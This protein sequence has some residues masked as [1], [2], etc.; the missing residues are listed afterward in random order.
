MSKQGKYQ[1]FN[2]E[3]E[4]KKHDHGEEGKMVDDDAIPPIFELCEKHLSANLV[5]LDDPNSEEICP[6]CTNKTKKRQIGL[7]ESNERLAYLGPGFP[8]FFLFMKYTIVM[9][10]AFLVIIGIYGMYSNMNGS[11]CS[12]DDENY[13]ADDAVCYDYFYLYLSL[14]NKK[15]DSDAMDIQLWLNF[16]LVLVMIV[17]IQ[18][19][20]RHVRITSSRCDERDISAADYSIMVEH[21]PKVDGVDYKKELKE[22]IENEAPF[23]EKGKQVKFEVCKINLTYNLEEL[24]RLKEIEKAAVKKKT[25][26]YVYK[27]KNNSYP[28]G[29][30]DQQLEAEINQK[31]KDISDYQKLL[32]EGKKGDFTGVAFVSLKTEQMKNE[33]I[34]RHKIRGFARFRLAFFGGPATGLKMRGQRLYVSQAAEPGDVYWENLHYTDKQ[35]YTR[36]F[37]GVLLTFILLIICGGLIFYLTYAESEIKD[38]SSTTTTTTTTATSTTNTTS[39]TTDNTTNDTTARLLSLYS[40]KNSVKHYAD[41]TDDTTTTTTTTTDD[42]TTDTTTT[43]SNDTTSNT[44]TDSSNTTEASTDTTSTDSDSSSSSTSTMATYIAYAL[45]MVIVIINKGLCFA[46]PYVAAFEKNKTLTDVYSSVATKLSLALFINSALVSYL[47][48]STYL[49]NYSGSSGLIYNETNVFV[50]NAFLNPLLYTLNIAYWLKVYK[51]KQNVK[52]ADKCPLTQGQANELWEN[53][54]FPIQSCSAT[55]INTMWFTAFYSPAIPLGIVLSLLSVFYS[56]WVLKWVMLRK[57]TIKDELGNDLTEDMTDMLEFSLVIFAIGNF[58]FNYIYNTS[59][60]YCV[61][62]ILTLIAAFGY[63]VL[64]TERVNE[65]L[66]KITTQDEVQEYQNV[67]KD[68]DNDYDKDNPATREEALKQ[69]L[70]EHRPPPKKKQSKK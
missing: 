49:E 23:T 70:E 22:L 69:E 13:S 53:P 21:I 42:S 36:K 34:A 18:F 6:C 15:T 41:S 26:A 39:T 3:K 38:S 68:F 55:L 7:C 11:S 61:Q 1:Q 19:M 64:P 40:H 63:F 33:L 20:R 30:T 65:M 16:V 10:T 17:L 52:L 44:T 66:F 45:A 9:L 27:F 57:T 25:D 31:E 28:A 46:I 8:L 5:G 58:V 48:T 14:A 47:V 60:W 29:V 67:T 59:N 54:T 35:A 24:Y 51:R 50:S 37:F 4:E 2:D 12:S 62:V 56:Y 43:S 32:A